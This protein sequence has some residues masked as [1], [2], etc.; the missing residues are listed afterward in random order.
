MLTNL[1]ASL[2]RAGGHF[3]GNAQFRKTEEG[4]EASLQL[5]L[6]IPEDSRR[7]ASAYIR[8]YA[9]ASGWKIASIR[10]DKGQMRLAAKPFSKTSSSLSKKRNATA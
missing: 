4:F 2:A 10:F 7:Y 1:Y 3:S 6:H 9:K 8:E 5:Q